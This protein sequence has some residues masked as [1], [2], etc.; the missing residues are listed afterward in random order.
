MSKQRI[1]IQEYNTD[2]VCPSC[3]EKFYYTKYSIKEYVYV[4]KHKPCCSW[5][6]LRELQRADGKVVEYN[7]MIA[8]ADG[9]R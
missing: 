5:H 9:I 1:P 4:F 2:R 3:G 8:I 6:C 7:Q